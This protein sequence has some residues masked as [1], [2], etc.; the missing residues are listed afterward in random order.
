MYFQCVIQNIHRFKKYAEIMKD[1]FPEIQL[2]VDPTQILFYQIGPNGKYNGFLKFSIDSDM[3]SQFK[4]EVI[5]SETTSS[6]VQ[7][8]YH[9]KYLSTNLYKTVK[10][11]T[12]NPQITLVANDKGI[13]FQTDQ[14]K[15][16]LKYLN[17]NIEPVPKFP[18]VKPQRFTIE[19]NIWSKMIKDI[20][21]LEFDVVEINAI[22]TSASLDVTCIAKEVMSQYE[23]K[24]TL[25]SSDITESFEIRLLIEHIH[26]FIKACDL[27]GT[28]Q[29]D[30]EPMQAIFIF[31]F[32]NSAT[33]RFFVGKK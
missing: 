14:T 9:K 27:G 21:S 13:V 11:L 22:H 6:G 18:L 2:Y 19:P 7:F 5:D 12:S 24:L 20:K 28:L 4:C 15:I 1:C 26:L 8:F 29:I 33:F 25:L 10:S 17:R 32:G 31:Q 3:I 23:R 16:L 30:I